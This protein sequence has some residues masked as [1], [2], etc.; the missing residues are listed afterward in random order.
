MDENEIRIMKATNAVNNIIMNKVIELPYFNNKNL[1]NN[2]SY[3]NKTIVEDEDI[4]PDMYLAAYSSRINSII[5]QPKDVEKA[6][7]EQLVSILLHE[8][9]HMLSSDM[10]NGNIGYNDGKEP[11]IFNEA[12]TQWL[13][14]KLINENNNM[15]DAI[16]NNVLYKES[17][18]KIDDIIK[19][20]GEENFYSHYFEASLKTMLEEQ[21]EY[22][23]DVIVN[24]LS[25]MKES[26]EEVLAEQELNKLKNNIIEYE[27]KNEKLKESKNT[28]SI[29]LNKIN[30]NKVSIRTVVSNA[31]NQ[32]ISTEHVKK[33]D[34]EEQ[35]LKNQQTKE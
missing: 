35:N 4:L 8:H 11:V 26:N 24:C 7:D 5:V 20:V 2:I 23:F 15:D 31:L 34:I 33:S 29:K 9:I 16:K 14:L 32:G 17:V 25:D 1:N 12:A 28:I 19:C 27:Q 22:N 18:K 21:N 3:F 6:T 10:K 13:T 30:N